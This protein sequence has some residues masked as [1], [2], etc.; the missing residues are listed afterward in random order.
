MVELT[1]DLDHPTA[2]LTA[3]AGGKGASLARMRNA[4]LPVPPGF[5]VST[6][7]FAGSGFTLPTELDERIAVVELTDTGA[8]EEVG[9]NARQRLMEAGVPDDVAAAVTHAYEA[10]GADSVAVRSSATAEDLPWASFAGQYDTF[11]NVA[12]AQEL[13]DRLLQVWA[14]LYST[15][16]VA[17]RKR[18]GIPNGAVSMAVVVQQ[19]LR[20]TASGVMFTHDPVTGAGD[21]YLVNAALGIGEGVVAGEV[22]ADSYAIDSDTLAI[23]ERTIAHKDTMM[24]PAPGGGTSLEAVPETLRS[25]PAL[26]DQQLAELAQLARRLTGLFQGPQD[27]EFA[28]YDGSVMLLQARPVTGVDDGREFEVGWEE[29]TDADYTWAR[30]AG[31]IGRGPVYRLEEDAIRSLAEG[32]RVCFEETGAP[33]T[34]NHIVR[35]FNGYPYVRSPDVTDAEAMGRMRRHRERDRAHRVKGTSLYKAEIGPETERT[36][37]ELRRF[38]P[39]S[40]SLTALVSHLE[41]ARKAYGRVM[42]DLHWRMAGGMQQDWPSTYHEIT[43]EPEVASG[44]L[45]QAIPNMT[46]RLVKR[47]RGLARL[48]QED[49]DLNA[50]FKEHSYHRLNEPPLRS[51]RAVSRFRA[52]FRR[53]LREYGLRSGRGFGSGVGFIAPTWNMDP[54]QPLRLIASYAEQDLV[55]LDRLD[56]RARQARLRAERRVRRRLARDPE[57]LQKF[58]A[59]LPVAVEQVNLMENHNHIMEQGVYGAFREAIHWMGRGLVRDRMLSEPD[60]A[61]HLSMAELREIAAGTGPRDLAALVKERK[62]ELQQQ[63]GLR[64]PATLGKAGPPP[65]NPM[66]RYDPPEGTGLDGTVLKGVGASPGKAVGR[67]RVVTMGTTMPQVERGDILVAANAGPAW[68]PIFP[69]LG[70][71]VLDQGAVFQHAALVAR[72]YGIPAVILTRDATTVIS[73]G[74]II[75]LDAEQ[76]LVDLTPPA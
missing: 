57:R 60:D 74:Q 73:D 53:L 15:R 32:H 61:F 27:I 66:T 23:V 76:G 71:L 44:T 37:A 18:L 10:M 33:M 7:A 12:G 43:G 40:A 54:G 39:R 16:A 59:A 34:R 8:L 17:Y 50:V 67:A 65:T 13:L 11:L 70:G 38:R 21:R 75:G 72:E 52:R 35:F 64:P 41:Q 31:I 63:A 2:R 20:P 69:L 36:L 24:A 48:V 22:P 6:R 9:R 58:D 3:N 25:L 30:P 56:V 14:S 49:T 45:L 26:T 28:V 47:L 55:R 1:I 62:A 5:V 19:Q 68:T 46:T 4:G 29:P 42:G 51:V